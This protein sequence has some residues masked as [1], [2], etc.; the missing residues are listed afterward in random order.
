ML[1]S[2]GNGSFFWPKMRELRDPQNGCQIGQVP[3]YAMIFLDSFNKGRI[4]VE[5][6]RCSSQQLQ[7]PPKVKRTI[8]C[9]SIVITQ[10]S[11]IVFFINCIII[12]KYTI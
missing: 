10:H 1:K 7:Q 5:T 12:Y 3:L 4:R 6:I 11:Q 8:T 2:E 9:L